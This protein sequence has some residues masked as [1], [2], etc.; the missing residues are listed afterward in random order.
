MSTK[1]LTGSVTTWCHVGVEN[2]VNLD[3]F[4]FALEPRY[5]WRHSTLVIMFI[6]VQLA[7]FPVCCCTIQG[8]LASQYW[9]W[10]GK[11][12][13]IFLFGWTSVKNGW[14][15]L[16]PAIKNEI[17]HCLALLQDILVNSAGCGLKDLTSADPFQQKFH[18]SGTQPITEWFQ[19]LTSNVT[20]ES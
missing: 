11:K 17:N 18:N 3:S 2:E 9:Q 5:P 15:V 7:Q 19:I 13:Q 20:E 12:L 8:G 16:R 10:Q 4:P 6:L 14:Q 1:K